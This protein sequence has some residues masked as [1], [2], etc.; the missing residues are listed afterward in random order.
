[1]ASWPGGADATA[2]EENFVDRANPVMFC[3]ELVPA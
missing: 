3:S 2:D 1:V